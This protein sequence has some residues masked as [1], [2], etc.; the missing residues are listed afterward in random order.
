MSF[1]LADTSIWVQHFRKNNPLLESLLINDRIICHPLVVLE[2][3][4]GSPPSPRAKT[5]E[6]MGLLRL[7]VLA[8]TEETLYFIEEYK[9][10]DSGCGAIDIS[11]LAATLLSENAQLWTLDKKLGALATKLK[12]GFVGKPH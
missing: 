7:A 9:L 5:I 3:A 8:G 1:V 11:L 6:Q 12:V 4:C 10:F 2:I